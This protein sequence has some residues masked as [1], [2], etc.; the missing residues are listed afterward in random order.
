MN[1]NELMFLDM[2]TRSKVDLKK[3]G[4]FV[5]A[6]DDST[7]FLCI[8][9]AF[10]EDD[11]KTI[12]NPKLNYN[13]SDLAEEALLAVEIMG[14]ISKGK[15][16]VMHNAQFDRTVWNNVMTKFPKISVEQTICT[17]SQCA[18][19]GLPLSL[20]K[21]GKSLNIPNLKSGTGKR[22][23]N[24]LSKPGKGG[25][26]G[27]APN[28]VEEMVEYCEQ[29]VR[30]TRDVFWN[31]FD[32]SLTEQGMYQLDQKINE[33][34]FRID[35]PLLTLL[36]KNAENATK[37]ISER[38]FSLTN[39]EVKSVTDVRGLGRYLGLPS[40]A[41]NILEETYRVCLDNSKSSNPEIALISK[42]R[43]AVI[44]CRLDAGKTSVKKIDAML[45]S[46]NLEDDR[47]R[48]TLV[49][50]GASTG[51]W[52]GKGCQPQNFP[53]GT[54]KNAEQ[55]IPEIMEGE[56]KP[57][58]PLISSLLR[59]CIISQP[60]HNLVGCDLS[61]I[62]ARVLAWISGQ[63]DLLEAFE[64]GE[65]V[66]KL[67]ASKIFRVP[68]DK[69]TDDQRFRGKVTVLAGGY[70]VGPKTFKEQ[71]EVM[72]GVDLP[73]DECEK[74]IHGY[75][76]TNDKIVNFWKMAN[77]AFIE[78]VLN[79][80][81]E[82]FLECPVYIRAYMDGA[83]LRVELPSKRRLTYAFAEVTEEENQWGYVNAGVSYIGRPK[84]AF[85][86]GNIRLYGGRITENLV[87]AIARDVIADSMME[88]ECAGFRPILSVHD[89]IVCEVPVSQV[90]PG[91]KVRDIMTSRP[92]WALGLPLDA[93]YWVGKRFRK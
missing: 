71:M 50:H 7:D 67:A 78:A 25:E 80:G 89:E 81:T 52:S 28:H 73:M 32:L 35:R 11:P 87:Q 22:L 79:G 54:I 58:L 1:P 33:R 14:H 63:Y 62:E 43:A 85:K 16:V 48:G 12:V 41:K 23:I 44:K 91:E 57:S 72:Y 34:G 82:V 55:H 68:A 46:A 15:K 31:T 75:R 59:S 2:E 69:V 9:V 3:A 30:T 37:E 18:A 5:Y 90:S 60:Y 13:K 21:A 86:H 88:L 19:M 49:Y 84:A 4:L 65:D 6:K 77:N 42:Q 66:Y 45:A 56:L 74:L 61:Q 93:D 26:F 24:L 92:H 27:A 36:K 38:L 83:H 39:G 40:V 10:G 53:R 29:D 70:Q 17:A 8:T 20:D 64:A 51:R 76:D 47:I